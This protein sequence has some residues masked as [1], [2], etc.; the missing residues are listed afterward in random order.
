[1]VTS[2]RRRAL[3]L[4]T[5]L[6]QIELKDWAERSVTLFLDGMRAS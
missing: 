1:V 5:P 2:P 3:G 6:T 4:G